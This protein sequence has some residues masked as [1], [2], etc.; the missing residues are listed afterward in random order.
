MSKL[1]SREAEVSQVGTS[2]RRHTLLQAHQIAA[3]PPLHR[4]IA[5]APPNFLSYAADLHFVDAALISC[6]LLQPH[7]GYFA[8][9]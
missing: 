2:Q 1:Q 9:T 5:T 7:C 8:N 4:H 6:A 3:L